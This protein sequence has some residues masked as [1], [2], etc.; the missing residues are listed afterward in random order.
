ML[1]TNQSEADTNAKL[2]RFLIINLSVV[3]DNVLTSR[4]NTEAD[5][6]LRQVDEGVYSILR[7]G[8]AVIQSLSALLDEHGYS[9]VLYSNYRGHPVNNTLKKYNEAMLF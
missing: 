8:K 2:K 4:V 3:F 6:V 7:D 9:L 5:L 1:N